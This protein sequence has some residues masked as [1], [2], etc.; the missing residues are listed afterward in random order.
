MRQTDDI[1]LDFTA[2]EIAELRAA[3]ARDIEQLNTHG[4]S[5]TGLNTRIESRRVR[6]DELGVPR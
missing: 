2:L 5:A 3:Q 1:A 6:L 4:P